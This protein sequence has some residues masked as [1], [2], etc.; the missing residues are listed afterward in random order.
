MAAVAHRPFGLSADAAVANARPEGVH[1]QAI[2]VLRWRWLPWTA[3]RL[4]LS[5]NVRPQT[6]LELALCAL[7]RCQVEWSAAG[8][9]E[10]LA[11]G[12]VGS[13]DNLGLVGSTGVRRLGRGAAWDVVREW[14]ERGVLAEVQPA[15][16]APAAGRV[17]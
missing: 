17:A 2:N 14:L 5:P 12:P 6:R 3:P 4:V 9:V 16:R 13:D 7:F 15:P 1:A 8:L 11:Q 10:R